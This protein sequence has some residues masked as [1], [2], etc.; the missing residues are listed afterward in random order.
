MWCRGRDPADRSTGVCARR[1][2]AV[3]AKGKGDYDDAVNRGAG[4]VGL[5]DVFLDLDVAPD[6]EPADVVDSGRHNRYVSAT[7]TATATD[8]RSHDHDVA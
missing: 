2:S 1:S 3:V 6:D 7:A 4:V 8:H 5:V